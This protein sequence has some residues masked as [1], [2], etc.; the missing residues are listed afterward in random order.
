MEVSKFMFKGKG[1]IFFK[2]PAILIYENKLKKPDTSYSYYLFHKDYK[3]GFYKNFLIKDSIKIVNK[4]SFFLNQFYL[5]LEKVNL[6]SKADYTFLNSYVENGLTVNKYFLKKEIDSSYSDTTLFYFN[7]RLKPVE[8]SLDKRLD[9]IY[10][11]KFVKM[12]ALYYNKIK[13]SPYHGSVY[14]EISISFIP[15]DY[16]RKGEFNDLIALFKKYNANK[17]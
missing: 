13:D 5:N 9:S 3:Y 17:Q 8:F 4:D 11:S 12:K 10:Q 15:G 1:Y 2:T 6:K 16:Q 7:D 14:R